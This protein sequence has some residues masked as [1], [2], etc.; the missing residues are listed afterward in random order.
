MKSDLYETYTRDT[1]GQTAHY[2]SV[3]EGLAE[4]LGDEG[5]RI[6]FNLDGIVVTLRKGVQVDSDLLYLDEHLGTTSVN[7]AVT[8]RG[9]KNEQ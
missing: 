6:S 9:M 5:Y 8:I 3:R 1:N 4:F 7:C 2:D